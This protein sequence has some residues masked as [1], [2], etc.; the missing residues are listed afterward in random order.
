MWPI[1]LVFVLLVVLLLYLDCRKPRNYPPGPLWYPI[2]GSALAVHRARHRTGMLCKAMQSIM[3]QHVGPH[4]NGVLGLKVG[5][6]RLVVAIG[7]E[8]IRE[9]MTNEDLDGR[10][11]GPFY[12][13]R[14]WGSRKGI[15]LTD[16]DFWVEQRRFLVRH[17]KEFGFARRGMVEMIQLEAQHLFEDFRDMVDAANA[18]PTTAAATPSAASPA[19]TVDGVPAAPIVGVGGAMVT[20]QDAFGRYILNTLWTMMAGIR[21]GRRNVQLL[22]LQRMLHTLFTN[23]DM[24]GCLFSHFPLLRFVAPR[25][26][27]YKQFVEIH[28]TMHAFL[29]R[30]L[31]NHKRR[32]RPNDVPN[33]LMDVYLQVLQQ[34]DRKK[35]FTE[36][37]LLAVCLDMFI[38]G[39]ETTTKTMGFAM[40]HIIRDGGIQRRI[41]DELD[42]VVG[43]GRLPL[44][45]DRAR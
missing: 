16:G 29:G 33:D 1:V 5:K 34:P 39:S 7:S 6:D 20:M 26:S 11:T 13:T 44:V 25:Y 18:P 17:L 43:R 12:E 21:Y 8:A 35:S 22:E 24:M 9:M 19:E 45:E 3:R 40:L 10:P 38:A 4:N 23:I 28:E 32:L 14:T 37:Q 15:L 36:K 2:V 42:A 41:Q 31:D 27:G 30:E